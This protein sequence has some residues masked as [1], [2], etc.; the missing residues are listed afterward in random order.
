MK[1]Y[2]KEVE[3]RRKMTHT[4]IMNTRKYKRKRKR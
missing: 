2:D 3:N 1:N 4:I